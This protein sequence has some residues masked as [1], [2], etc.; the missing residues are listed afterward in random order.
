MV[1]TRSGRKTNFI[2]K[3]KKTI[4]KK[5]KLRELTIRLKRFSPDELQSLL[6]MPEKKYHLRPRNAQAR[7]VQKQQT[8]R[9][10]EPVKSRKIVNISAS[11]AIW[12]S[13]TDETHQFYPSD[14]VLAKMGNFRPWPARINSIYKVGTVVKCYVLFYGTFQIGSVLKSQCVKLSV[15]DQYL[16]HTVKEIKSKFKWDR[17]DYESISKSD[18]AQ[19]A[20]A[21]V[22]LTQIQK[23]FLAIRDIEREKK[24]PYNRSMVGGSF[25][26]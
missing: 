20:S 1:V 21:L 14:I 19:R 8:S 25:T 24:V 11:N 6:K 5:P 23:L 9:I 17:V 4:R 13:L 18:D 15:C 7:Q 26:S 16:F 12:N 2:K 3:E 10:S 22:K